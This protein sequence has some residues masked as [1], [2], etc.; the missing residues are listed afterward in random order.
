[1]DP[2]EKN[3]ERWNQHIRDS[4]ERSFYSIQRIDL[5]TISLSGGGIIVVFEILKFLSESSESTTSPIWL[6]LIGAVFAASIVSNLLSQITGQKC[7]VN[8]ERYASQRL[9]Y[10]ENEPKHDQVAEKRFDEL[11]KQYNCWTNALTNLGIILVLIGI[12]GLV[13]FNWI[14]F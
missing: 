11:S 1:M 13:V 9:V 7:N 6:K 2:K 12:L 4:K 14:A 3:I 8:E 5:L 10:W